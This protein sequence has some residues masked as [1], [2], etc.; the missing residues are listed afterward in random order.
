MRDVL[1]WVTFLHA[2]ICTVMF[3]FT[4]LTSKPENK[5]EKTASVFFAL[6]SC[7]A[8]ATVFAVIRGY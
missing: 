8:A 2:V 6:F 3:S 7:V 5:G 1:L 4:Y